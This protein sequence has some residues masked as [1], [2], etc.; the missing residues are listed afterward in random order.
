MEWFNNKD[1]RH[2]L[3]AYALTAVSLAWGHESGPEYIESF[4]TVLELRE[5]GQMDIRHVIDV[6]P[7]GDQIQRGVFFELPDDIGPLKG[8][9]AT[10]HGKA[11][12]PERDSG[13]LIVAAADPLEMHASHRFEVAYRAPAP[14]EQSGEDSVELRWRP[15]IDQFELA[16][17]ESTL[18]VA[19][20]E[21][22]MP[23]RLPANGEHAGGAW[24]IHYQG[25]VDGGADQAEIGTL[26]VQ[27]PEN[28]WPDGAVRRDAAHW[29]RR[30]AMVVAMLA[31]LGVLHSMWRAVG[32]DRDNDRDNDRDVGRVAT[33]RE[34][35]QGIS[36]AAGR[37]IEQMGFD[38]T[39]FVAALVSLRVK[40]RITLEI[41][42]QDQ[43]LRLEQVASPDRN[44]T[45]SPSEKAVEKKLFADGSRVELAPGSEAGMRAMKA[46]SKALGREH[47]GRHFVT[48]NRQRMIGFG[49][50]AVVVAGGIAL[51][52]AE[53][54]AVMERDPVAIGL[55]FVAVAAGVLLPAI[56]FELLKAPTR[57]G[58]TVRR[59]IAALKRHL[60]DSTP[61]DESPRHFVE[62]LPWAIALDAEESWRARFGDPLDAERDGEVADLVR[63]YRQLVHD[64]DS[65]GAAV[66]LIA[67]TA[68]ATAAS[69]ASAGGAS[70]GGV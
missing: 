37:Y 5:S 11:I 64:F 54:G 69:G 1:L 32:R 61:C 62:L 17:R 21:G 25:S 43:R 39:A 53:L 29:A 52:V 46:L 36:P 22:R 47:R 45:S 8:F 35:P 42:A 55:G 15:I 10:L 6:H 26:E 7:H 19:W 2:C 20:P 65:I 13:D 40:G 23:A 16:W 31:L 60:E 70:A 48:N 41:D 68:G 27:W 24:R 49:L 28:A 33:R 44:K 34:P 59:E 30:A 66:P 56:Y 9:S 12:E 3:L 50:G 14:L 57:A 51:L 63:W 38:E 58:R 4:E 67:A 18:T